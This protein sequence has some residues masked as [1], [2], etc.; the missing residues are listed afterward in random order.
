MCNYVYLRK[1]NNKPLNIYAYR[2]EWS[3]NSINSKLLYTVVLDL[4]CSLG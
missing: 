3:D 2:G 4:M 1:C